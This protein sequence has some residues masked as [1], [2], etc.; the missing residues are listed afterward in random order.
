MRKLLGIAL[1]AT[2]CSSVPTYP[3]EGCIVSTYNGNQTFE[4]VIVLSETEGQYNV[5]YP[6]SNVKTVFN[7]PRDSVRF[8]SCHT[9][10]DVFSTEER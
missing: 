4:R 10:W 8:I 1:L 6:D 9:K 3:R 5:T 7:V 2:S